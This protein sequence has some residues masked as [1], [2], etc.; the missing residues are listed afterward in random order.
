MIVHAGSER[1]VQV[2]AVRE[3]VDLTPEQ[4]EVFV[5]ALA[6]DA[7]RPGFTLR[8]R[9]PGSRTVL[10]AL[11]S[12]WRPEGYWPR[13]VWAV[14]RHS[15]GGRRRAPTAEQFEHPGETALVHAEFGLRIDTDH[16]SPA[17]VCDIAHRWLTPVPPGRP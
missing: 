11:G 5:T 15:E 16:R 4:A 6:D 10:Q 8:D 7:F 1:S 2:N 17:E 3:A 13:R 14:A 9:T 12:P